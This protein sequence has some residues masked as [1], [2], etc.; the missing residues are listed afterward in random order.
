MVQ[1]HGCSAL[2]GT[3]DQRCIADSSPLGYLECISSQAPSEEICQ[4]PSQ[5]KACIE[6]TKQDCGPETS[7]M[8]LKICRQLERNTMPQAKSS[9][10]LISGQAWK[11]L[12]DLFLIFCSQSQA[13]GCLQEAKYESLPSSSCHSPGDWQWPVHQFWLGQNY[14]SNLDRF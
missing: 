4:R 6:H 5:P 3:S 10:K 8:I 11:G 13:L 14:E 1:L 2:S 9:C 12:V 7:K